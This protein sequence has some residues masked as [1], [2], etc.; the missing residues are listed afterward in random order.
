MGSMIITFAILASLLV[1]VEADSQVT[2]KKVE[3]TRGA[4]LSV[5][6]QQELSSKLPQDLATRSGVSDDLEQARGDLEEGVRLYVD[7]ELDRSKTALQGAI[8]AYE[9]VGAPLWGES[10]LARAHLYLGLVLLAQGHESDA[11]ASFSRGIEID[12]STLLDRETHGPEVYDSFERA[13]VAHVQAGFRPRPAE[14]WGVTARNLGCEEVI[15][16]QMEPDQAGGRISFSRLRVEVN[17]SVE[18]VGRKALENFEEAAVRKATKELLDPQQVTRNMNWK[19]WA[20][21]GAGASAL[22]GGT[23][24][25]FLRQDRVTVTVEGP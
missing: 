1:V 22:L 17:G 12:R 13:R 2:P 19:R 5:L 23:A 25:Y 24:Y 11:G 8:A 21:I 18:V 3:E 7:L 14:V 9:K 20:W 16:A 15:L 4:I 6:K 10:S